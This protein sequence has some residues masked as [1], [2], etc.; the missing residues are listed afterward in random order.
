MARLHKARLYSAEFGNHSLY[1]RRHNAAHNGVE[2]EHVLRP[3]P[4]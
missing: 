1:N 3:V 4:G 2:Y